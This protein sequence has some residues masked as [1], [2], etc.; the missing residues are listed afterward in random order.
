[1][2]AYLRAAREYNDAFDKKNTA[3]RSEI[4]KILVANTS[5][6]D[7]SLYDQMVMPRIDPTGQLNMRS[8]KDD[9]DYFLSAG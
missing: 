8:L 1:M 3:L 6:K 2:L 4:V 9:Q 7:A 5:V